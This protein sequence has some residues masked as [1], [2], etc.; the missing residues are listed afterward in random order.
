MFDILLVA[1][2]LAIVG[3]LAKDGLWSNTINLFNVMLSGILATNYFEPVANWLT[4]SVYGGMVHYWDSVAFGLMFATFYLLFRA[5]AGS[6]S[7]YRLRF[8]QTLDNF[9][10]IA[11]AA[12][13]GWIVVCLA[14]FAG[15]LAPLSRTYLND[16]F[17]AENK[18]FFG[19]APDR[20]W[21]GFMQQL[22]EGALG[23]GDPDRVFD[24][25]GEFMLKYASRRGYLNSK[26][27]MF[28]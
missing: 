1:A 4:Q 17:K 14:C 20:I 13:A 25:Q 26:A 28:D 12:Y 6:F 8:N 24:P 2:M 7:D 21:L 3:F 11:A 15:H 22:S 10:G 19:L 27:E 18:M 9:G 16:S 23:T 5:I